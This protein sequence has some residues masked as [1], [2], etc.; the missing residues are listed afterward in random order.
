MSEERITLRISLPLPSFCS[1]FDQSRQSRICIF[2][3]RCSITPIHVSVVRHNRLSECI[4]HF[5]DQCRLTDGRKSNQRNS[6]IPR[7]LHFEA[8]A[9]ATRFRMCSSFLFLEFEL[10]NL[11]LQLPNVGVS[12]LVLLRLIDLS[13]NHL[14]LLFNRR[15]TNPLFFWNRPC[16]SRLL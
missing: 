7:L 15:H 13:A 16:S 4:S 10:G 14:D 2:A 9:T 11:G 8:L 1:T 3:P 12:G 6:S 5:G